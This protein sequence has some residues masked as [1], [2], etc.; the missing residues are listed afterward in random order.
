MPNKLNM[1]C[2]VRNDLPAIQMALGTQAQ[3]PR[4]NLQKSALAYNNVLCAANTRTYINNNF[5]IT[6][7][8]F[9]CCTYKLL[10]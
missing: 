8:L 5:Y 2:A 10:N 4:Q 6:L 1:Q 3:V 9:I 7:A